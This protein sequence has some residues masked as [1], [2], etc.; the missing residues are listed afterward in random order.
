MG[1]TTICFIAPL[2]AFWPRDVVVI[3]R[4]A[5]R[6]LEYRFILVPCGWVAEVFL[7]QD[8]G[9]KV[10]ALFPDQG[11]AGP[12]EA[13]TTSATTESYQVLH[14]RLRPKRFG[15]LIGQDLFVSIIQS[16]FHQKKMPS[17]LL[18]TGMRGV[19]KT[20]SARL[21]ARLLNCLQP[22]SATGQDGQ[23]L[24]EPCGACASCKAFDSESHT[25]IIEMDAASHTGVDDVRKI[26]DA[27]QYKPILGT[28][29]AFIVDEVHMLSKSAFN[30]FLKT[31]EAPPP[32]VVFLFATTEVDKVPATVLSRCL[33]F[34]MKRM[35]L[36]LLTQYLRHVA[37]NQGFQVDDTALAMLVSSSEGSVRDALSLLDQALLTAAGPSA[38]GSEKCLTAKI[39]QDMLGF[40]DAKVVADLLKACVQSDA[41]QALQIARLIYDEGAD[42]LVTLQQM[43]SL[44]HALTDNVVGNKLGAF[45]AQN[46]AAASGLFWQ[47]ALEEPVLKGLELPVLGRLWQMLLKGHSELQEAPIPQQAFEMLL[48]RLVYASQLPGPEALLNHM[49]R[50][51]VEAPAPEVPVTSSDAKVAGDA[52]PSPEISEKPAPIM[53][54]KKS[55]DSAAVI[56]QRLKDC[57]QGLLLA[58]LQD[59]TDIQLKEPGVVTLVFQGS[60]FAD[61]EGKAGSEKNQLA[62][63]LKTFLTGETGAPWRVLIEAKA[64][65]VTLSARDA[66]TKKAALTAAEGWPLVKKAKEAFPGLVVESAQPL[67]EG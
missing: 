39:L 67:K 11:S 50:T 29:K 19:G 45:D 1:T 57:R 18:F 36:E 51:A 25:D 9:D 31:L 44:V 42:P 54:E 30:A 6:C 64:G 52:P 38:S 22:V 12:T 15:D 40:R 16:A 47:E 63:R 5:F 46:Q 23:K 55:L 65:A 4:D 3:L 26:L 37:E 33:R 35:P 8:V 48:V 56:I 58:Q 13:K 32:H 62:S 20:T 60:G 21:V 49:P 34:H 10:D 7:M 41:P 66:E 43:S 61:A 2:L 28:Y 27:C 53:P 14:R 59:K 17:A 24:S